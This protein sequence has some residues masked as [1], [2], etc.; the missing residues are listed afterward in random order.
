MT[1][2]YRVAQTLATVLLA[3]KV[4]K[5]GRP[6]IHHA[7]AVRERLEE[8]SD[9][10]PVAA[11][12]WL[13]DLIEDTPL[14]LADLTVFGFSPGVV[15]AVDSLTR[16]KGEVYAD[17]IDRVSLDPVATEVKIADLLDHLSDQSAIPASLVQRYTI[18][19]GRLTPTK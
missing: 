6:A 18:A 8:A 11:V 10:D 19:L 3:D 17:Y 1:T 14:S 2:P 13:H 9:A 15:A 16:R 4:D 12:A 7:R 5:A